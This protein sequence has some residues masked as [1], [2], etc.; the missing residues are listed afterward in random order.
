MN[1][2]LGVDGGGSSTTAIVGDHQGNILGRGLAGP[3]NA[4][5][6]IFTA[7]L[8]GAIEASGFGDTTFHAA[9]LGLSGSATEERIVL[10]REIIRAANYRFTHDGSIALTGALAGEPGIIVISGTGSIAY[11]KNASNATARA[12][13]WGFAFGDEGSAFDL[14]RRS[15]RAAL[16][17]EEGWGP[18]TGLRDGLLEATGAA[19]ASDLLHRFYAHKFSR[20][21]VAA[22]API[23]DQAALSGDPI[24]REILHSAAQSLA[25]IAAA[26]RS[27]IFEE[28]EIVTNAYCGGAFQSPL[29]L[30]R[31]RTLIELHDG[32]RLI[33]QRFT[34][35]EGA[36]IE[37]WRDAGLTAVLPSPL[38]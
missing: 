13:G 17:F 16:Q 27:R 30:D 26:V 29:L 37:A 14:V 24:A 20:H 15:L 36:L 23:V 4:D 11:G 18:P 19:T 2:F 12:G 21:N 5:P 31:F 7:S 33:A 22:L 34:S 32:N 8:R 28:A 6:A 3:C 9:C 25:S 38:S 10:A 1:L 35:A